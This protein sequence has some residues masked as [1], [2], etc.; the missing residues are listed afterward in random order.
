MFPYD[1]DLCMH[2]CMDICMHACMCVCTSI[3][4]PFRLIWVVTYGQASFR[5]HKVPVWSMGAQRSCKAIEFPF[6]C[7][8]VIS[9]GSLFPSGKLSR[10]TCQEYKYYKHRAVSCYT[11]YNLEF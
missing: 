9:I 2:M 1:M 8:C 7:L 3:F 5:S 11:N 6:I 10:L 4:S